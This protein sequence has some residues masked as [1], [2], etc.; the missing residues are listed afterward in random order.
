V[1]HPR[2]ISGRHPFARP[3]LP[4]VNAR[5]DG[6]DFQAPPSVSSLF[7]LVHGCPLPAD[8]CS[9]LP[10]YHVLSMSGSTRPR[11]PGSTRAARQSATRVV[12]CRRDKP[13]GTPDKF[14]SGLNTFKGGSTRYLCTSPAFVPTHRRVRCRPRRKAR[15]WARGARLPRRDSHPL[16]HAALPGRTVPGSSR[17]GQ[18]SILTVD[19]S[20]FQVYRLKAGRALELIRW[21]DSH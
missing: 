13:V 14:F 11:T 18:S 15:Y 17:T 8:R 16:D 9:D 20:D 21:Y 19:E 7:T 1:F 4:G 2:V 12:A 10:G 6:S 3:A 5:M